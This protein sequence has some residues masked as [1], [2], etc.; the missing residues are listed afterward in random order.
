MEQTR[1][2]ASQPASPPRNK[3]EYHPQVQHIRAFRA[4]IHHAG[5]AHA[6][7]TSRSRQEIVYRNTSAINNPIP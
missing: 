7:I 1:H 6:Y 4:C 3:S 2:D 5:L